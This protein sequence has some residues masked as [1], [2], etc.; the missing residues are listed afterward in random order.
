MSWLANCSLYSASPRLSSQ[1]PTSSTPQNLIMRPGDKQKSVSGDYDVLNSKQ[2]SKLPILWMPPI[3]KPSSIPDIIRHPSLQ[4]GSC[5]KLNH[6]GWIS[7][8]CWLM[9]R[10]SWVTEQ[11]T[12]WNKYEAITNLRALTRPSSFP[13]SWTSAV[14]KTRTCCVLW[15][16]TAFQP[17]THKFNFT[18]NI[19]LI[20]LLNQLLFALNLPNLL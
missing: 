7:S 20:I 8:S 16:K 11:I 14:Q 9:F 1:F 4:I 17:E 12:E 10:P 13:V 6:C 18:V 3:L 5:L 15:L 19:K 2:K